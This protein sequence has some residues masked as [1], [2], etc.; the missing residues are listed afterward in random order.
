ML[1][2]QHRLPNP[3]FRNTNHA[4]PRPA[5]PNGA[6]VPRRRAKTRTRRRHVHN[7]VTEPRAFPVVLAPPES[8]AS[9]Q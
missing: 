9:G 1:S 3:H 4:L 5:Y 8:R 7:A 2:K 6:H